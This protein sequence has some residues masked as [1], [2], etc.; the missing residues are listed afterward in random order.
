MFVKG[1]RLRGM[2]VVSD[3]QGRNTKEIQYTQLQKLCSNNVME[4]SISPPTTKVMGIRNA[5]IL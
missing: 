4:V 3:I 5:R 2:F 1:R